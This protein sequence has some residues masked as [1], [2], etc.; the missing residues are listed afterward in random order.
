MSTFVYNIIVLEWLGDN[1]SKM[2]EWQEF[3]PLPLLI[4]IHIQAI[5]GF[6]NNL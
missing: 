6:Q 2:W 1:G 4:V 3:P 5:L